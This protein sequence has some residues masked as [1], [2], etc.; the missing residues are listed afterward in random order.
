MHLARM[1]RIC[2]Q[3]MQRYIKGTS[4]IPDDRRAAICRVLGLTDEELS[5]P[6]RGPAR[7]REPWQLNAVV[8]RRA[9]ARRGWSVA[10]LA[11]RVGAPRQ[12]LWA[13]LEGMHTP[14]ETLLV[15]IAQALGFKSTRRLRQER[16]ADVQP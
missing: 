12:T 4:T 14:E 8:V 15:A 10:E 2:P 9:L 13:D 16:E 5:M 1:T 3:S 7:L 6:H 11:R